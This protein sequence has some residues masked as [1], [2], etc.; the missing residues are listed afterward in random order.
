[1]EKSNEMEFEA[2][3]LPVESKTRVTVEENDDV[4]LD[5]QAAHVDLSSLKLAKDGHVS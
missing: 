1:M 4:L 2:S 5:A 3:K